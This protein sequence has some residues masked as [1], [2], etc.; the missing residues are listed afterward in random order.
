MQH[1]FSHALPPSRF[2]A[3]ICITTAFVAK[4]D[5]VPT[6][7]TFE[8]IMQA[9]PIEDRGPVNAEWTEAQATRCARAI[10]NTLQA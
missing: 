1:D 6:V 8:S 3:D 9:I 7:H 4:A 5:N 10:I 2:A